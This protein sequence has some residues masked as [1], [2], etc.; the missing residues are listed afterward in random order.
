M[1]T[2]KK[3]TPE[4]VV[5]VIRELQSKIETLE[6]SVRAAHVDYSNL[7]EVLKPMIEDLVEARDGQR[8]AKSKQ[9]SQPNGMYLLQITG[10]LKGMQAVYGGKENS[11]MARVLELVVG[12]NQETYRR[13]LSKQELELS[14][15]D[16]E[17]AQSPESQLSDFLI[18]HKCSKTAKLMKQA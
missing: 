7:V 13:A 9:L 8:V 5:S 11:E 17:S 15:L 4:E 12:Y 1:K 16:K 14:V 2:I 10:A 18:E 3:G 6:E